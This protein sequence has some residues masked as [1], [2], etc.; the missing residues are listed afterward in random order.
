VRDI[1]QSFVAQREH[2][3]ARVLEKRGASLAGAEV[4]LHFRVYLNRKLAIEVVREFALYF[5]TGHARMLPLVRFHS[6]E[7]KV[8]TRCNGPTAQ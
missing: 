5:L 7:T 4:V 2:H 3:I 6:R 1:D 8:Y